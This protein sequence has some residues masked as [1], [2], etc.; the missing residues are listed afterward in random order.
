[1]LSAC[2]IRKLAQAQN[3]DFGRPV[4][5]YLVNAYFCACSC[6]AQ[7]YGHLK[8]WPDGMFADGHHIWTSDIQQIDWRPG[9]WSFHTQSGSYY[10]VV[11][12]ERF[13]GRQSLQELLK[14]L[15]GG[16]YPCP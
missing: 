13:T 7:T 9:F 2:A 12:F 16:V 15:V 5:A 11:T 10:V 4:T 6:V 14:I 8:A 1:M 3:Y